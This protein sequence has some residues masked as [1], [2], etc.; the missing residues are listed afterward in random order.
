MSRTG[1]ARGHLGPGGRLSANRS[2]RSIFELTPRAGASRPAKCFCSPRRQEHSLHRPV[3]LPSRRI[4]RRRRHLALG[5]RTARSPFRWLVGVNQPKPRAF[6]SP[7]PSCAPASRL[8]NRQRNWRNPRF[9]PP[10]VGDLCCPIQRQA[11]G[12]RA[13]RPE[14]PATKSGEGCCDARPVQ[15]FGSGRVR[16][17]RLLYSAAVLQIHR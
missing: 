4:P 7:M 17:G 13:L 9:A 5:R 10:A 3:M 8:P 14:L 6:A 2:R 15:P 11:S 16:V 1:S 12:T